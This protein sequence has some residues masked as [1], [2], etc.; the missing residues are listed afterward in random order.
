MKKLYAVFLFAVLAGLLYLTWPFLN[1]PTDA[2]IATGK[3]FG[4]FIFSFWDV[5]LAVMM[6][7]LTVSTGA[8]LIK[9]LFA[10]GWFFWS[11]GYIAGLLSYFAVLYNLNLGAEGFDVF[12]V[13][14]QAAADVLAI[15]S[16]WVFIFFTTLGR[17][18]FLRQKNEQTPEQETTWRTRHG[19]S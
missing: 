19:D 6:F 14:D 4:L 11:I 1:V 9:H 2:I 18:L 13:S 10:G 12:A 15:I 16:F 7:A 5:A 8:F 17:W 3:D